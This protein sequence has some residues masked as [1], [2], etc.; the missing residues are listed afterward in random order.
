MSGH[1]MVVLGLLIDLIDFMNR[2]DTMNEWMFIVYYTVT[3][4][5]IIIPS[6]VEHQIVCF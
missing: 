2:L 4:T 1:I 6:A 5:A 3:V